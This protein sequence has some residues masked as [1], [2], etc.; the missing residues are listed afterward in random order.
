MVFET[1]A[2]QYAFL[3]G[4]ILFGGLLGFMGFN[5]FMKTESMT[6]YAESKGLPAPQLSV[7]LSGAFLIFGGLSVA[8][9]AYPGI[10]SLLLVVFFVVVT[11]T[12]HDFWGFDDPEQ[13][14]QEMVKFLKNA[15][16]AGGA[17]ILY[18]FSSVSWP[19]ALN[20]VL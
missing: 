14:Q 9:G 10:G 2:T 5:H 20:W 1:T 16:M 8:F 11:P 4:R 12:M 3:I 18:A 17:L 6:G 13:Q 19:M 15:V 7:L